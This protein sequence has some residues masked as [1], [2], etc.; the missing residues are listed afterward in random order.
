MTSTPAKAPRLSVH[1]ITWGIPRG[2]AFEPWLDEVVEVGFEGVALFAFQL[3]DFIDEPAK[4]RRALDSRGL[5]LNAITGMVNDKPEWSERV[6]GFMNELGTATLACT[7]FGG[8]VPEQFAHLLDDIELTIPVAAE[9]L[10]NRGA[11]AQ[12]YGVEVYYHNHTG[13]VGETMTQLE[14]LMT[15]LDPANVHFMLDVGHAT[16]DF[17]ELPPNE[18]AA[19]FLERHW[20]QIDYLE[21]K[22]W[23]EVTDLNTPVG[24]GYADYDRIFRLIAESGYKG[25]WLTV[26][27]NGLPDPES[28]GR[29]HHE[30]AR[31]SRDYLRRY[32]F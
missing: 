31:I 5:V 13:G 22:D 17:P 9:I 19:D 10:N 18:R 28:L 30:C 8:P 20:S 15:H 11:A 29:S 1:S 32:G 21:L 26:E 3:E 4:L 24:E 16:K 6:H 14:E 12:K 25:E 27:Q 7:D 2:D 23:N